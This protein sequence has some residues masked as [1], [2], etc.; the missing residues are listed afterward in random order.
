M[1]AQAEVATGVIRRTGTSQGLSRLLRKMWYYRASYV[2][3]APFLIGFFLFTVLPVLAALGISLTYYDILQPPRW[4]GLQNFYTLFLY[5]NVFILAVKNTLVYGMA[6]GPTGLLLAFFFAWIVNR[7]RLTWRVPL[8]LALYAPSLQS[9]IT[10]G[11]IAS[12]F[13]STDQYGLMNY[14][15]YQMGIIHKPVA[16]LQNT[17]LIMPVLIGITLW[18]SMGTNFLIFLAGLQ[19]VKPELYEAARVDGVANAWQELFFIT[20]PQQK[21]F[22]LMSAIF[23]VVNSFGGSGLLGLAGGINSPDYAALCI[24]DYA[25]D[26]ATTRFM[27]GYAAAIALLMFA[28]SYG[29][30]R[31]LFNWLAEK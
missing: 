31:V 12:Y 16:W 17:H 20:I 9:T 22:L 15:L 14:T 8:T 21:P 24:N 5:D 26:Y 27:M 4:V 18:M 28:W 7:V 1:A 30:G 2:M 25:N 23:A 19:T 29:L 10:V 6:T 13:F 3:L 11:L